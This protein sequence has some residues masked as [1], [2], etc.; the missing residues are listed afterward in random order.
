[1]PRP[2]FRIFNPVLQGE[3][4]DPDGA[5]VRRWVPE[6][7]ALAA[8]Y[9]HAPWQAP[10]LALTQAGVTLG[11]S[12]PRPIVDHATARARALAAFATLRNG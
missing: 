12:Y 1:M 4:F 8:A 7:G 10:D 2:G 3:K 11:Q 6:L 5:Y 9:L